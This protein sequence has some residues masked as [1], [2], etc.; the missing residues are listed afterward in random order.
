[1]KDDKKQNYISWDEYFIGLIQ[2]CGMRSKD[3]A[4]QVGC[5]IVDSENH[6]IISLGYNGLP[7]GCN[8]DEFPWGRGG[9][10]PYETKYPYVVH[11]E[12]NAILS[13]SPHSVKGA[14]LY[15]SKSPCNECMKSIIQSGIKRVI[16]IEPYAEHSLSY[17][18]SLRMA[19]AAGVELIQ[20][21]PSGK[22]VTV[23]L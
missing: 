5:C 23:K 1:M 14:T 16:Y 18:S 11:A 17:S 3:P 9:D 4:T 21:N 10:D 19:K 6:N 2:L 7:R 12:L 8:D 15:V 22:E 20:Y 13:A